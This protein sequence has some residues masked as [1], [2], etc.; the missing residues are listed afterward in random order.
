MIYEILLHT[1]FEMQR[2]QCEEMHCTYDHV[3][4]FNDGGV[5]HNPGRPGPSLHVPDDPGRAPLQLL[6]LRDEGGRGLAVQRQQQPA[7]GLGAVALHQLEHAARGPR[8]R[9]HARDHGQRVQHEPDLGHL[10]L[11]QV[12]GVAEDPISNLCLNSMSMI[13]R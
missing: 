2:L 8:H 3:S 11:R 9:R 12:L 4:N 7:A 10:V 13:I 1:K 6:D 5:V